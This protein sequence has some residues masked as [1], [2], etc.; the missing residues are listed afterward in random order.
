[1]LCSSSVTVSSK[2]TKDNRWRRTEVVLL[3]DDAVH[4][5]FQLGGACVPRAAVGAVES[6]REV[7]E[8]VV[9]ILYNDCE[10]R[11]L[12]SLPPF[13][14]RKRRKMKTAPSSS[15]FSLS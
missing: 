13:K 7:G 10:E 15:S 8:E 1:M 11:R 14:A 12:R 9:D 6:D 5:V 3:R 2:G 4:R